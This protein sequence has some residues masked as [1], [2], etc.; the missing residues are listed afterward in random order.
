MLVRV[1]SLAVDYP[2]IQELDLNPVKVLSEGLGCVAVDYKVAV[3][4]E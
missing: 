3:A 4:S 2:A 1:S